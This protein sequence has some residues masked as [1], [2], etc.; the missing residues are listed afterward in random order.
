MWLRLYV[1]QMTPSAESRNLFKCSRHSYH[2]FMHS[3]VF[4]HQIPPLLTLLSCQ[5]SY[6]Q[7]PCHH[8]R[9]VKAASLHLHPSAGAVSRCDLAL[10]RMIYFR[11]CL[12]IY[13]RRLEF[14]F[15]FFSHK[16]E[17]RL[18]LRS[19][20]PR[21]FLSIHRPAFSLISI[22]PHILTPSSSHSIALH[23]PAA[24]CTRTVRHVYHPLSGGDITSHG[25]LADWPCPALPETHTTTRLLQLP[26]LA[27][28]TSVVCT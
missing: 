24:C 16:I 22:W 4:I 9:S 15:F 20:S 19:A 25:R 8:D 23:I 5:G 10:P 27:A 14:P 3:N 21:A 18:S 13:L 17:H 11:L 28:E 7:W 12:F 2:M 26:R 1:T 6:Y